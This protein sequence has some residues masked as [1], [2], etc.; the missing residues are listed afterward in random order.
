MPNSTVV[1]VV[2]IEIYKHL[3]K[4]CYGTSN[5]LAVNNLK[6]NNPYS[7]T[8]WKLK[9]VIFNENFLNIE[10]QFYQKGLF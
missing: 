2:I 10:N 9:T 8:F 5:I 7:L 4:K 6:I 1:S 3:Q